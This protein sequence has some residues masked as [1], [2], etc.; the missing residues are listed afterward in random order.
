MEDAHNSDSEPA[1]RQAHDARVRE[2]VEARRKAAERRL[3]KLANAFRLEEESVPAITVPDHND[4]LSK[5]RVM[6]RREL[7]S[8]N[9]EICEEIIEIDDLL[10][11]L[12]GR[13]EIGIAANVDTAIPSDKVLRVVLAT[14]RATAALYSAA[15]TLGQY[16][17]VCPRGTEEERLLVGLAFAAVYYDIIGKIKS[18]TRGNWKIAGEYLV[19]E[20]AAATASLLVRVREVL[21]KDKQLPSKCLMIINATKISWW[22]TSHHV[23]AG[24]TTTYVKKACDT[25]FP[26]GVIDRADCL[27]IVYNAGHWVSTHMVL[28]QL[29]INTG[30]DMMPLGNW[31]IVRDGAITVEKDDRIMFFASANA[32]MCIASLPAGTAR[33]SLVE[34]AYTQFGSNAVFGFCQN[35]SMVTDTVEDVQRLKAFAAQQIRTSAP[36]PNVLCRYHVGADYLLQESGSARTFKRPAALGAIGP[37]LAFIYPRSSLSSSPHIV[38]IVANIK[39]YPYIQEPGYDA[40]FEAICKKAALN[41]T[42]ANF[43]TVVRCLSGAGGVATPYAEFKRSRLSISHTVERIATAYKELCITGGFPLPDELIKDLRKLGLAD[44]PDDNRSYMSDYGSDDDRG[45]GAPRGGGPR[46]GGGGGKRRRR[47]PDQGRRPGGGGG[48]V[49]G[50]APGGAGGPSGQAGS[51]SA[52]GTRSGAALGS[53]KTKVPQRPARKRARPDT[54]ETDAGGESDSSSTSSGDSDY[55]E[56]PLVSTRKQRWAKL[57]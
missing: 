9:T 30:V 4:A 18:K 38:K 17:E 44:K 23:G 55:G 25:A 29:G 19:V 36:E 28:W 7:A 34:S 40:Q 41:M 35:L 12:A 54:G 33:H 13:L 11:Y 21:A 3:E 14:T 8:F 42:E 15:A 32:K 26:T 5:P 49:S 43:D 50:P 46:G 6:S 27:N 51:G 57:L 53:Q 39:I 45:G 31:R 1:K 47:S 16:L 56:P 37:V 48:G 24:R 2:E 20:P 52:A 10:P 22:K